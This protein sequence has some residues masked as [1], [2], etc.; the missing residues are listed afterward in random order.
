MSLVVWGQVRPEDRYD[1]AGHRARLRRSPTIN[2][3][4]RFA[5]PVV[6]SSPQTVGPGVRRHRA[7]PPGRRRVSKPRCHAPR[8]STTQNYTS[9]SSWRIRWSTTN[10]RNTASDEGDG[11]RLRICSPVSI[12]M[13]CGGDR[14]AIC[15]AVMSAPATSAAPAEHHRLVVGSADMVVAGSPTFILSPLLAIS[16]ANVISFGTPYAGLRG[17][18]GRAGVAA[19][20]QI[21]RGVAAG[22]HYAAANSARPMTSIPNGRPASSRPAGC[23]GVQPESDSP[24]RSAP[25]H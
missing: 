7:T 22:A 20:P 25:L 18:A 12:V 10:P 3:A 23:R 19:A 14:S 1:V 15:S 21:V 24:P 5:R 4:H 13:A 16:F 2:G 8:R 9:F 11:R 17:T 6:H